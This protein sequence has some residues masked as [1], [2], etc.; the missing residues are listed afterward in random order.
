[1][2][3]SFDSSRAPEPVGAFPHA[4]RVGDGLFLSGLGPRGPAVSRGAQASRLVGDRPFLSDPVN[5]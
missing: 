2:N 1:M 4:R 3:K 5:V